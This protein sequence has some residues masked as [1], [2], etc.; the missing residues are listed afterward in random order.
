MLPTLWRIGLIGPV[1]QQPGQ[2]AWPPASRPQGGEALGVGWQR[3]LGWPWQAQP[4][5]GPHRVA[6][7]CTSGQAL[8]ARTLRST[9]AQRPPPA[10]GHAVTAVARS[11][12][13]ALLG[14]WRGRSLSRPGELLLLEVVVEVR[15]GARLQR[16]KSTLADEV[17]DGRVG[18]WATE[19]G[20]DGVRPPGSGQ[21]VP[22]LH[23]PATNGS[24]RRCPLL[25][26][27]VPLCTVKSSNT[28]RRCI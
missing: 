1:K 18:G 2:C 26:L 22:L 20:E 10:I 17:E 19:R 28:S 24:A 6:A 9:P 3:D 23:L 25:A 12:I 13:L 15:R 16:S 14:P 27:E 7:C 8:D 11:P 4:R 21:P 5:R